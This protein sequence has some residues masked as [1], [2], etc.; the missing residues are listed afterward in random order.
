M[1]NPFVSCKARV[2]M[3][4]AMAVLLCHPSVAFAGTILGSAQS[5]AVLGAS[6]VTNTGP[7]TIAGDLGLFPGTSI[8]DV[9]QITL[10]GTIHQTDA[11]ARQAQNDER[12]AYNALALLPGGIS[13]TGI[14]LGTLTLTPGVYT[15]ASDAMLTGTL[16][17]NLG[18]VPNSLFVFR[19]GSTLTTASS[20]VVSVSGGAAGDGIFW[21][22][23]SSATL[24]STTSFTGNILARDSI[25]M[26]TKANITCGRAF[27]QTGAVTL[28]TNTISTNCT[29]DFVS[30]PI[31][32]TSGGTSPS[33]PGLQIVTP[34]PGSFLLLGISL[35]GVAVK[36]SAR[37]K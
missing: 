6:T 27:A 20:A 33:L 36:Y 37:K 24:G 15:F 16:H 34:E 5:F 26:V 28:D 29:N 3:L 23:G 31:D 35:L 11:A 18:T 12:F 4:V 14:D 2:G 7:T 21:L 8:T 10:T 17:L 25:T 13:E 22:V 32:F 19:I 9:T 1:Q 30:G